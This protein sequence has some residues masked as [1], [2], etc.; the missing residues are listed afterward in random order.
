MIE[1]NR[2]S[3]GGICPALPARVAKRG[4]ASGCVVRRGLLLG[5][6]GGLL[7]QTGG[8][9]IAA[10]EPGPRHASVLALNP[11]G[12]WPADEGSGDVLHD[13]TRNANHGSLHSVP[14]DAD[15]RLLDFTGAYQWAE[16]P[17][18]PEYQSPAFSMGG[19]VFTR[20]I[21]RGGQFPGKPPSVRRWKSLGRR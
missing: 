16:I 20:K 5:L 12:Y 19:W 13:R 15:K 8:T 9:A 11:V 3:E 10:D 2:N 14:W 4:G 17:N 7:W 18:H 21:V 6:L 1:T